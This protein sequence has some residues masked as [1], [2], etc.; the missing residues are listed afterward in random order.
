MHRRRLLAVV[1]MVLA[2][3]E[4]A[5]AQPA[6]K[7]RRVGV[8]MPSTPA[9]TADLAAAFEQGLR[10]R[11]Y[12]PGRDLLV[13]YRYSEGRLDRVQALT[14]ELVDGARVEV[15][16]S[17]TDSVVQAIKRHA[18]DTPIVMVNTSDP[19]GN[20]LVKTL[21][22]PQGTVTGVTNLSPEIGA[23]RLQLLKESVPG[24][25]QVAYLWNPGLA[26]AS[27]VRAEL[28]AAAFKLKLELRS[29]EAR[30]VEDIA[31]ALAAIGR[32]PPTAV[33]VQAP[34]PV[35][36]TERRRIAELAQAQRLPSMFN[37][38]EYVAAGGLMSY[39]PD[40]P[41]MYR[42]AA[43]YVDQ[44]FKGARPGELAVEQPS[45]FELAINLHTAQALGIA[46]PHSVL[47]RA[48]RTF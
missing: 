1:T 5:R 12:V 8:L 38:W 10:E 32:G 23:K 2:L 47:G 14:R 18:P 9:A 40:V 4:F 24:L 37:R 16:V 25:A 3:P 46:V 33:L 36:Y 15:I 7:L 19:V 48:D 31:P 26:G 42:R 27:D 20:A 39:G 45:R 13:E 34:N 11:G 44:I 28:E 29:L 41:D 17:T 30:R 43:A 6:I 22:R 35:F 21:A